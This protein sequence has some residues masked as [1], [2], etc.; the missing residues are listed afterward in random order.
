MTVADIEET[1]RPYGGKALAI[2]RLKA[3]NELHRLLQ[4][5]DPN[6]L[7]RQ[8]W[9]HDMYWEIK[10]LLESGYYVTLHEN[11]YQFEVSAWL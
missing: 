9:Q 4:S 10:R 5:D 7:K 3:V 11:T 2:H 8:I 1:Y 6:A